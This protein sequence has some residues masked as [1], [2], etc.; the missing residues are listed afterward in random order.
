MNE[1]L[2][3]RSEFQQ[4]CISGSDFHLHVANLKH[5]ADHC[6]HVTE[7]GVR[8]GQSTR[9]LL[10]SNARTIRSFDL[11]IDPYVEFLFNLAR[12][13]SKDA[14]YSVGNTLDIE[15]EETDLLFIDTEHTYHQLT[16][17]LHRHAGKVRKFLAFHDTH[18]P[19]GMEL[20]PA[21]MEF[22]AQNHQWRVRSH[23]GVCYGFTVLERHA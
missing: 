7:F 17:E 13:T 15:I 2:I 20:L 21:I 12:K 22:L 4:A 3:L 18:L 19:F 6:T 5:L 11:Y 23:T 9:G 10:A 14:V 16:N 8:D 1:Q